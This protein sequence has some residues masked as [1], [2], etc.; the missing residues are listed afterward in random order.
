MVVDSENVNM[1]SN[2]TSVYSREWSASCDT[3]E[4]LGLLTL[5]R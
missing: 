1:V 4:H 3:L 2:S 5:D